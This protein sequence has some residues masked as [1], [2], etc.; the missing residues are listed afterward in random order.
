MTLANLPSLYKLVLYHWLM[1]DIIFYTPAVLIYSVF[2]IIQVFSA[3]KFSISINALV[4]VR[5]SMI[6]WHIRKWTQW[7]CEMWWNVFD[8]LSDS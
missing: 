8:C 5:S 6:I 2:L 1:L 7:V 3:I 4:L